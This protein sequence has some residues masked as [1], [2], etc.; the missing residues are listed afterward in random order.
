[1]A[2]LSMFGKIV[3]AKDGSIR[4]FSFTPEHIARRFWQ[5]VT[6]TDSCWLWGGV[7]GPTGY[8][9]FSV[10]KKGFNAHRVAYYLMKGGI[11]EGLT[12]DHL[13]R[14][15]IC[16]N[17]DHLDPVTS[18]E[19]V[20]RAQPFYQPVTHCVQGHEYT[21]DNTY[22]KPGRTNRTCRACHREE[23]RLRKLRKSNVGR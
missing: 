18:E 8:G 7:I 2:D 11:P 13:C 6:K 4:S 14:N 17:P 23:E 22:Y 12:L 9:R 20:R 21:P 5:F 15:R 1:M 10:G 19:N 3:K 16:V